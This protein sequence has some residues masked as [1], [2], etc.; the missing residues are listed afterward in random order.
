MCA[1]HVS[2]KA[3]AANEELRSGR[4]GLTPQ[5]PAQSDACW[6]A[7]QA[8]EE[9]SI[10]PQQLLDHGLAA[11]VQRAPTPLHHCAVHQALPC[12]KRLHITRVSRGFSLLDGTGVGPRCVVQNTI[13]LKLSHRHMHCTALHCFM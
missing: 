8:L 9:L 11:V 5:I 7:S 3:L 4:L 2:R 10:A 13:T 6:L 1:S 12:L